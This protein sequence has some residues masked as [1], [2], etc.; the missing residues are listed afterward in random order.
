MMLVVLVVMMMMVL[1]DVVVMTM[2]VLV[3]AVVRHLLNA[4][5]DGGKLI[6]VGSESK[7]SHCCKSSYLKENHE[8][9][10]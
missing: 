1:V 4:I 10:Q 8:Q 2:M 7:V 9:T 6:I 3:D 5:K